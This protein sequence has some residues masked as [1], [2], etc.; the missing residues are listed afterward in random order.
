MS[1]G[2]RLESAPRGH[3]LQN[4][5]EGGCG[6]KFSCCDR[7]PLVDQPIWNILNYFTSKSNHL[8]QMFLNSVHVIA[9]SM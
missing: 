9:L 7:L 1:K 6:D 5:E 3:I 4:E 8:T 2:S